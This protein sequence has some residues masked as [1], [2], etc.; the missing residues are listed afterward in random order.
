LGSLFQIKDQADAIANN[1]FIINKNIPRTTETRIV[2][3]AM[4]SMVAKVQ[5]IYNREIDTLNKYQALRFK[6]SLTGLHNRHYFLQQLNTFMDSNDE[7]SSGKV[8][9]ISLE[10][11]EKAG[12]IVEYQQR[13]AFYQDLANI[14]NETTE[15]IGMLPKVTASLNKSEFGII[16]PAYDFESSMDIAKIMN[17]QISNAISR[18]QEFKSIVT[19]AIGITAYSYN[20]STKTIL[21]SADYA[22]AVAK[23]QFPENIYFSQDANSKILPG[24]QEWKNIIENA[25]ENNLFILSS[26]SVLLEDTELHREVF[27][28][29]LDKQKHVQKCGF[30]MPMVI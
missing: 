30:F 22:L 1:E 9:I 15:G 16:L 21:S 14:I 25:L 23:R 3:I 7:K 12:E 4:N 28:S 5:K 29:M 17:K 13:T 2:V 26:Q 27:T 6:D 18:Q 20:D 8:M 24:K 11:I 10:G 19:N